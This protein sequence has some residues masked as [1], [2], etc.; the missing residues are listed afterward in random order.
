MALNLFSGWQQGTAR[1]FVTIH[2]GFALNA[3]NIQ[4]YAFVIPTLLGYWGLSHSQAGALASAALFSS[5][6]GGWFAGILADRFGRIRVLK[7]SILWFAIATCLCGLSSSYQQLFVA[8]L[9]QG[10]GFGAEIAIGMVFI[11]EVA[12]AKCRSR[13]VGLAQ[14]GWAVGWA[15]AALISLLVSA[16]LPMET[17]WRFL[18]F[19]GLVPACFI[20]IYRRKLAASDIVKPD[21]T[22]VSWCA[23]FNKKMCLTTLKG[24]LLAAGTHTGYWAIATWWPTML[25]SER[26]LTVIQSGSHLAALISGSFFGY[27]IGAHL[28]DKFGR[29]YTLGCFALSGIAVVLLYSQVPTVNISLVIL[30]FP[31]GFV[32]T[33]MYGVIGSI[34]VELYP[35]ELRGAGLGFCYNLGRGVAGMAPA[36]IGILSASTGVGDAIALYVFFAYGIVLL[37]AFLLPETRGIN[38]KNLQHMPKD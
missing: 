13:T 27:V 26:G 31:L 37:V 17:A 15:L 30:S 36:I 23:I 25:L 11:G 18:F 22:P 38:L 32:A 6:F 24:A 5:A 3:F 9:I 33:G 16:M 20:F 4:I 8:R 35:T 2:A 14:S 12:A 34:L 10:L 21:A 7:I 28:G 1:A 19:V 29:R